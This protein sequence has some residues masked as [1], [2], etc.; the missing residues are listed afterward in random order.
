MRT[1]LIIINPSIR[2]LESR[3]RKE[4]TRYFISFI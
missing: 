2:V 4:R 3:G 1:T